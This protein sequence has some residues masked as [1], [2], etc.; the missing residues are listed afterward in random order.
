MKRFE[1]AFLRLHEAYEAL[2]TSGRDH[3][4]GNVSCS[5][6]D[7][8]KPTPKRARPRARPSASAREGPDAAG[9][10]WERIGQRQLKDIWRSA[11]CLLLLRRKICLG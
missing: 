5:D 2:S 10:V 6:S 3:T 9:G 7:D 8:E 11:T 4:P 1:A